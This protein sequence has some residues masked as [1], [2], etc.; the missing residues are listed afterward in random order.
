MGNKSEDTFFEE[1]R[2]TPKY[3]LYYKN[4]KQEFIL[5][6]F[7]PEVKRIIE[8]DEGLSTNKKVLDVEIHV[9]GKDPI[10]VKW[11]K[12]DY[13]GRELEKN[14]PHE[15][16]I[17]GPS[18]LVTQF[19]G[20]QSRTVKTDTVYTSTGWKRMPD[21]ELVYLNGKN[22]ICSKGLTDKYTVE[23]DWPYEFYQVDATPKECFDHVMGGMKNAMPDAI[24][25]P[26]LAYIHSGLLNEVFR[27]TDDLVISFSYYFIGP[28]GFHKTTLA[29]NTG[30]NSYGKFGIDK[31]PA[32]FSDTVND[33]EYKASRLT[34]CLYLNDDIRPNSSSE[35]KEE[36]ISRFMGEH[37]SRGRLNKDGTPQEQKKI[38]CTTVITAEA[39]GNNSPSTIARAVYQRIDASSLNGDAVEKLHD[40]AKYF[41]KFTQL[42]I[43]YI[44]NNFDD[45]CKRSKELLPKFRRIS[46]EEGRHSRLPN[47]CSQLLF[48]Y[49]TILSFLRSYEYITEEEMSEQLNLAWMILQDMIR[50]QN[51]LIEDNKP[52]SICRKALRELISRNA[53]KL[54]ELL[55]GGS[56]HYTANKN[57]YN[58]IGYHDSEYTYLL[59][60]VI[61]QQMIRYCR[62]H[63]IPWKVKPADLW[64][65]FEAEGLLTTD[66]DGKHAARQIFINETKMRLLH[67]SSNFLSD[68]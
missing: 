47:S 49:H 41:N 7:F 55:E 8:Y 18:K 14:L 56:G 30:L 4:G 45:I 52:T 62:D 40:D 66:P 65:Q 16:T 46:K 12:K 23:L 35:D 48:S 32:S 27:A 58:V 43:Q 36:R 44:I 37:V 28:T 3:D 24:R 22:S 31:A 26:W 57:T 9:D 67:F 61:D 11:E 19:I 64:R 21:G 34:D 29:T 15:C 5:A 25:I 59:G 33:I 1:F 50:E 51:K 17:I 10:L 42:Y 68:D 60:S 6:D 13:V 39:I 20:R 54:H 53:V 63:D 38:Y 2:Y